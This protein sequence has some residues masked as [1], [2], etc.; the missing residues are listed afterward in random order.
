MWLGLGMSQ[1]GLRRWLGA[2]CAGVYNQPWVR[3]RS[4]WGPIASSQT[5]NKNLSMT[6]PPPKRWNAT[7]KDYRL[8]MN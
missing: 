3:R 4:H 5:G 6:N 7:G 8:Q 2:G 1:M